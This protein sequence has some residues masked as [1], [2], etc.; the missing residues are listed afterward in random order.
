MLLPLFIGNDM[1]IRWDEMTDELNGT[2][3][4]DATV[5]FT[6]KDSDGDGVTGAENIA[7]AYVSASDGRYQGKLAGSVDLDNGATYYLE[8]TATSTGRL[9]FRKIAC[10]AQYLGLS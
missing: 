10:K 7:M 3:I 6:L 9:G 4:N 1:R 2:F 8:I 5:T